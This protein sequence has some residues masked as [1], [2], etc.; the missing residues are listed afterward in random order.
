MTTLVKKQNT[1]FPSLFNEFFNDDLWGWNTDYT[2]ANVPAV[3]IAETDEDYRL[4]LAA[5]GLT[6]D[7]IKIN[8][9]DH[10]LVIASEKKEEKEEKKDNYYR[11]EFNYQ[12]F[13]RTFSLPEYEVEEDKIDAHYENGVLSIILPKR[14]EAK[15]KP[16]RQID[17]M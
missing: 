2:K 12:G 11:K 8:V 15:P 17:I 14:E 1:A 3:N 7:D 9:E 5:P 4:E 10:R 16:A 13:R 6:K